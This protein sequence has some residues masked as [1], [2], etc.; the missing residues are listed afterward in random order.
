MPVVQEILGRNED[1]IVGKDGREMVRFHSVFNGLHSVKQVQ[2]IQENRDNI[3]IKIVA[4]GKLDNKERQIM[5]ERITSQLGDMN[6]YFDCVENIPL[7][8]NG[9]FQAVISKIKAS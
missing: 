6:I 1:T 9:K 4:D 8:Q 3:V 2:V 7:N 5:S